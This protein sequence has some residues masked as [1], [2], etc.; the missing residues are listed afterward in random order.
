ML[1]YTLG[2][3]S[4]PE[5]AC[6]AAFSNPSL[7]LTCVGTR[8]GFTPCPAVTSGPTVALHQAVTTFSPDTS[9]DFG[10]AGFPTFELD[11]GVV[12][13]SLDAAGLPTY[14][15]PSSTPTTSGALL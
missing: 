6:R 7:R 2:L 13:P 10:A 3:L 12:G 1:T 11:P 4:A 9:P 15:S 5:E 8:A 14:A